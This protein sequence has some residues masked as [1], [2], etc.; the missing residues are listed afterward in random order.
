MST[1]SIHNKSK[2][3]FTVAEIPETILS[4]QAVNL[5]ALSMG[6]A[7]VTHA[8]LDYSIP[9]DKLIFEPLSLSF[10]VDEDLDNYYEVFKWM[11][12]F[13]NPEDFSAR[14]E[15]TSQ[16][17]LIPLTNHRNEG[18]R[19]FK[20]FDA[21]PTDL[22][23]IDYNISLGDEEIQVAELQITYSYFKFE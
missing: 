6:A 8:S 13:R 4:L 16:C 22:G 3:I 2:F 17:E 23:G 19:K 20:F 14:K 7:F 11:W 12:D 18:K 15:R 21:F 1:E 10:I 5:P 9:G